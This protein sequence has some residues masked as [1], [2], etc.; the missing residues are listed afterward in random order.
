MLLTV[1]NLS[2]EIATSAGKLKVVQGV[3]FDISKGETLCIV[4][5]SGCGKS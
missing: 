5:E 2:I 4:G 3:S 1:N